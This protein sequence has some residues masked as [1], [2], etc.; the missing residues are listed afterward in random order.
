MAFDI[1]VI[2]P[3]QEALLLRAADTTAIAIDARKASKYRVYF[4]Q[5][6]AQGVFFQPL[7]VES[8]G[9]WDPIAATFLKN[10]RPST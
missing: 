1:S 10:L 9:G 8:L 2:S 3:T 5:C 6:Q 4:E 7:V